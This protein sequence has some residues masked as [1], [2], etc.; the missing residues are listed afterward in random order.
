[1]NLKNI[2]SFGVEKDLSDD[3]VHHQAKRID[4]SLLVDFAN[5]GVDSA[6]QS[7]QETNLVTPCIHCLL[8][9]SPVVLKWPQV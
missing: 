8:Q 9:T 4:N 5:F 7:I 6:L 2:K 3:T 1:M